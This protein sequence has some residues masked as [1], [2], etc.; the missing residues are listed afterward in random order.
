VFECGG[1][2]GGPFTDESAWVCEARNREGVK[3]RERRIETR[4]GGGEQ[5]LGYDYGALDEVVWG[6]RC[7][8]R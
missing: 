5:H 7:G 3:P 2:R 1:H 8:D 6:S 4:L